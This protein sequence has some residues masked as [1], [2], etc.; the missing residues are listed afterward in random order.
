M[1]ISFTKNL[2]KILRENYFGSLKAK[3]YKIY[4]DPNYRTLLPEFENLEKYFENAIF[5]KNSF[6]DTTTVACVTIADKKLVIKRYNH[7]NFWHALKL[8]FRESHALRSFW[9][10]H[11]LRKLNI[12]TIK[13]VAV[14]QKQSGVIKKATYFISEYLDGMKGCEYFHDNS[15]QE[16]HWPKTIEA[17]V[18]MFGAMKQNQLYH[19][20]FHFG[21]LVIVNHE[22]YLLDFDRIAQVKSKKKFNKL[23]KKDVVNFNRYVVRNKKA[24]RYFKNKI[25][26]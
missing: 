26:E 18:M 19:G 13:P 20:D 16:Q 14:I 15:Q 7:K 4:Y 5:F 9:Y 23:R 22:P 25:T 3:G 10:A 1:L 6:N 21:N 8:Q 11:F 2:P 12:K 24:A 17:V